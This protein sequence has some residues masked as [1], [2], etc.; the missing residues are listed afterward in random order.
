MRDI[1]QNTF[2]EELLKDGVWSLEANVLD[3]WQEMERDIKEVEIKVFGVSK[4]S[5]P[6]LQG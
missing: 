6:R 3:L 5:G 2:K 1:N 4:G